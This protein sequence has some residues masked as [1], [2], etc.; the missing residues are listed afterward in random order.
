VPVSDTASP[1]SLTGKQRLFVEFYVGQANSNATKAARLAGYAVP[2]QEGYRLLRNA[3]IQSAIKER[4][5]EAIM[6][7]DEALAR[8][9]AMARATLDDAFEDAL[10]VERDYYGDPVCF[11]AETG[12][13]IPTRPY[14]RLSIDKLHETGLIHCVKKISYNQWGPIVVLNDQDGALEKILRGL[15][16]FKP[17]AQPIGEV[18]INV[19]YD[20]APNHGQGTGD[21]PTGSASGATTDSF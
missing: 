7:A 17:D 18:T 21:N 8:V 11:D 20:N 1:R 2:M 14:K 19:K 5:K 4:W 9:S 13:P 16:I 6:S 12:E 15:G 10:A 3:D